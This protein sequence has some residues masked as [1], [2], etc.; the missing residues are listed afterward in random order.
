MF[1]L[2][3]PKKVIEHP[4]PDGRTM[5]LELL[6]VK[7]G[8]GRVIGTIVAKGGFDGD[9]ETIDEVYLDELL[10]QHPPPL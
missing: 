7:D 6:D 10:T 5:W 2:R 3:A 8:R 4:L 1:R 9:N